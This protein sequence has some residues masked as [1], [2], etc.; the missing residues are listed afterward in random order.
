MPRSAADTAHPALEDSSRRTTTELCDD[1]DD[2]DSSI[3]GDESH[4]Y[5]DGDKD[6]GGQA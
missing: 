4:G 5:G 2:D 1:D 3:D 6:D